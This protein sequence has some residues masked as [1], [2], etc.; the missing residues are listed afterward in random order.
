MAR[1]RSLTVRYELVRWTKGDVKA[2]RQMGKMKSEHCSLEV[3]YSTVTCWRR[4]A[5]L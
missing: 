4:A 1:I 3:N 2:E 5:S